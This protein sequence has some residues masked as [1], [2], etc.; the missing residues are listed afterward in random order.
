MQCSMASRALSRG[1]AARGARAQDRSGQGRARPARR[2][3]GGAAH[4]P[5]LAAA[6]VALVYK[7]LWMIEDIIRSMKS[8]PETR[9]T[10]YH[11]T[12]DA[13]LGEVEKH[14]NRLLLGTEAHGGASKVFLAV[15]VS[16]PSILRRTSCPKAPFCRLLTNPGARAEVRSCKQLKVNSLRI[17]SVEDRASGSAETT[18]YP[19]FHPSEARALYALHA[20]RQ[21]DCHSLPHYLFGW[22]QARWQLLISQINK[23][24]NVRIFRDNRRLGSECLAQA[25]HLFRPVRK[26]ET[27]YTAKPN[28]YPRS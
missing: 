18:D 6:E 20:P 1:G 22:R 25:E 28:H 2:R 5:D 26:E 23:E 10:Y 17:H 14:D 21:P 11:R 8:L 27:I 7:Q 16:L 13:I 9:P 19:Q 24:T 4:S 15:G 12:D 3:Q